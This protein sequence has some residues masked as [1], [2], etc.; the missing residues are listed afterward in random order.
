MSGTLE[1]SSKL[2]TRYPKNQK[3]NTKGKVEGYDQYPIYMILSSPD[4]L[5]KLPPEAEGCRLDDHTIGCLFEV[6]FG[7]GARALDL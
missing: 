7:A 3:R 5:S 1:G 6:D 2:S 4:D